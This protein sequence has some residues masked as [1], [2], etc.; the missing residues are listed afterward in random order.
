MTLYELAQRF[1][2]EV[3]EQGGAQHDPFI[4]WCH[5]SCGL[6]GDT[7]DEVPWCSRIA[8]RRHGRRPAR[9]V[10]SGGLGWGPR[11]AQPR[12]RPGTT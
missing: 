7:P 6:S 11:W 9:P 12:L 8:R 5:A 10:R 1:V 3:R 4:Q 2:G